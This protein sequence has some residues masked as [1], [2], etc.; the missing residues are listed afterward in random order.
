MRV[1]GHPHSPWVQAVLLGLHDRGIHCALKHT[2]PLSIFVRAGVMMPAAEKGEGGWQLESTAILEDVGYQSISESQMRD[3]RRAWIGL[4]HRIDSGAVFWS[5]F[6]LTGQTEGSVGR[7]LASNFLRSFTVLYFHLLLSIL[8][9]SGQL[10]DPENYGNQ[11]LPFED[12]LKA[13]GRPFLTGDAPESLD[14]LLFG[15][16][17]S[18][19]STYVPPVEALQSDPRLENVRAWISRMQERFCDYPYLYSAPYFRPHRL[20][21]APAG[22]FERTAFWLGAIFWIGLFPITVPVILALALRNRLKDK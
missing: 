7:R 10:R 9:L 11:F 8:R 1:Y 22:T 18:H 15:M 17:Q 16:I 5:N 21:P 2:P 13:S 20:P 4:P 12:K 14:C 19:C 6:S 3:I